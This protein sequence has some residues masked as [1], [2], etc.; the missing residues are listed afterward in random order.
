M[1]PTESNDIAQS[2]SQIIEDIDDIVIFDAPKKKSVNKSAEINNCL[3]VE[4]NLKLKEQDVRKLTES[5]N[6]TQ[7][8]SQIIEDEDTA[9]M[10]PNECIRDV[11]FTFPIIS[12]SYYI[13]Y[14]YKSKILHVKYI[15]AV[16]YRF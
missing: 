13:Y 11:S 15:A 16:Y 5:N 1:K 6:I 10:D 12:F 4:E 14:F 2:A 9:V 3:K 8:A 7:S